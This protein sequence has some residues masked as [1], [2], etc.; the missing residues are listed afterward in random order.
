[1]VSMYM[2]RRPYRVEMVYPKRGRPQ[3]YLARDVKVGQ[4]RRK[5]RLY[6][7]VEAPSPA[8]LEKIRR[9]RAVEIELKAAQLRAR[10]SA[11]RLTNRSLPSPLANRLE[12]ARA[13]YQSARDLMTHAE[14][15]AYERE[16]EMAY[17]S[18]TTRIE[19]NTLT[20]Q[21]AIDLWEHGIVPKGRSLR[22][23]NEVQNFKRVVQFRNRHQG[24]VTLEFIRG[25]HALV[26]DKIDL[27]SAGVFR[28]VD[29]IGIA[30]CDI[31]VGPSATIEEDL[32][33]LVADYYKDVKKRVHP[34]EAAVRFHYGFEIVHPFTDGNGRVGRELLNF[35]LDR[36]DYPR[37]LFLGEEREA[38]LDALRKGN[39]E[40]WTGLV[41]GFAQI[42]LRQRSS[43][44]EQLSQLASKQ[45]PRGQ[46][47]LMDF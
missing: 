13:L 38:Y 28:R 43:L 4:L 20:K 6:L 40:D 26:M 22:E 32:R 37:I 47:R 8:D 17:V 19:G 10:L 33:Q 34:F 18:G 27:E 16:F 31:R 21:Q 3:Y 42:V 41:S 39:K 46:L 7:G 12:E 9:T 29:D 15:L 36:A 14:V 11:D 35:M 2:A 25:L 1:M 45:A 23:I 5:V 24:K 30:G 44:K